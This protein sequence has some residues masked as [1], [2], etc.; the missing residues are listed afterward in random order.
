MTAPIILPWPLW[1][2]LEAATRALFDLG[3]Q[4]SA[5]FLRPAGEAALVSP[6]SLSCVTRNLCNGPSPFFC[7]ACCGHGCPLM[8]QSGHGNR[9]H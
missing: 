1:S 4:Y 6:D 9:A 7:S 8:A 2:G 3:D 5:D